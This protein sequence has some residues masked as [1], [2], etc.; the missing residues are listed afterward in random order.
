MNLSPAWVPFL[1]SHGFDAVHWA[2]IGRASAADWEILAYSETNAFILFTH[3]LDFGRLLAAG[4]TAGPSVIQVREQDV[5]P[6]ATGDV[7]IQAINASRSYLETGALVT[8]D[9]ARAR[10][11]LLPIVRE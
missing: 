2:T 1:V 5:L 7:V 11:R 10:I 4:R 8:V 9:R 3:D 6:S